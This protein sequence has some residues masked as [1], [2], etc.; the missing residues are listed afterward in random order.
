MAVSA[1]GPSQPMG[2]AT[3]NRSASCSTWNNP[4]AAAA[5]AA[6]PRHTGTAGG[7]AAPEQQCAAALEY[8]L[9]PGPCARQQ[10]HGLGQQALAAQTTAAPPTWCAGQRS[11][12]Q[13]KWF[14][15][16]HGSAAVAATGAASMAAAAAATT[17][18]VRAAATQQL[19]STTAHQA[20]AAA[21]TC[22][23]TTT[24]A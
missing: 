14:E 5:A 13:L 6:Q 2:A 9:Q 17:S 21:A 10:L 23:T 4:A 22:A 24:P 20:A 16:T 1:D 7:S 11:L 18:A 12:Q 3:C 15:A 8:V 19:S